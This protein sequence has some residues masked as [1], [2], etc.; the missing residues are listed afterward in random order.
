ME[1]VP[2]SQWRNCSWLLIG[3]LVIG[4]LLSGGLPVD[5]LATPPPQPLDAL[6]LSAAHQ[7]S[8]LLRHSELLFS[9]PE[10]TF[11]DIL[12]RQAE[13]QPIG[14]RTSLNF[15]F[16]S[17]A[18]WLHLRLDNDLAVATEHWLSLHYPLLDYVDLWLFDGHGDLLTHQQSGDR[19]SLAIRTVP[20]RYPIFP[21]P[22][23]PG[24]RYE[25]W[26]RV[27]TEGS[28]QLPLQL[29]TPDQFWHAINR[30]HLWLYG[31]AGALLAM[32]LFN[33]FL[34]GSLRDHNYGYYVLY[35]TLVGIQNATLAGFSLQWLWPEAS[36]WANG[37]IAYS[38]GL[39]IVAFVQF[40]RHFLQLQT[41]MPRVN[42]YLPVLFGIVGATLLLSQFSYRWAMILLGLLTSLA[43]LGAIVIGVWLWRHTDRP[44]ARYYTIAWLPFILSLWLMNGQLHGG[45][46]AYRDA[47]HSVALGSVMEMLLLSFAL[48]ARVRSLQHQNEQMLQRTT[49]ELELA[50]QQ[51]TREL[52][53]A[54]QRL[55]EHGADMELF[56]YAMAHDLKA[57][58]RAISGF[59]EALAETSDNWPETD[60]TLLQ[61]VRDSAQQLRE[62]TDAI[63][64]LARLSATTV[65]KQP[66]DLA[67]LARRICD[68][69][70]I[71]EPDRAVHVAI[72]DRLPVQGD[73]TLLHNVMQNLLENA[74]KYSAGQPAARIEVGRTVHAGERS[75]FVRD[76]GAGFDMRQA[77]NLFKPFQRLHSQSEFA[78]SGIGLAHVSK[79]IQ[80]H[81]GRIWAE[82]S[83][84]QGA[85]FRFTLPD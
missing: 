42:R 41:L 43:C 34:F 83:P 82:A 8:A 56:S 14:Q 40:S 1:I 80:R 64:A 16:Q 45:D 2:S 57:P 36:W 39:A 73:P 79:I 74:W 32:A 54:N 76:N 13:F 6:P 46:V 63:I 38:L 7:P 35:L 15:G 30:E 44:E 72:A 85:C 77:G 25:L 65:V 78:G 26:L 61:R 47:V 49:A 50:V 18:A 75:Y 12:A 19:R 4:G 24:Q 31:Y 22:L 60:R 81:G 68:E 33:L 17:Q 52:R 69:L 51:R 3:W 70:R 62:R 48:A 27:H 37:A 67:E 10:Q 20:Y 9:A 53:D 55:A 71:A 11:A 58:L 5:A 28:L 66:V 59:S 23:K 84:G 21:L 29:S